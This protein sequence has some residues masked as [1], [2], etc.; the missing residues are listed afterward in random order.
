MDRR[1]V[2]PRTS[3]GIAANRKITATIG[4]QTKLSSSMEATLMNELGG[5][6]PPALPF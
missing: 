5:L 1:M 4:I 3:L 6:I 2:G